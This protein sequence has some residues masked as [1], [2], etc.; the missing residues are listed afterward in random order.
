MADKVKQS[1]YNKARK[2][3][4]ILALSVPDALKDEATKVDRRTHHK[5]DEKVMPDT[6]QFSIYGSVVPQVS[7]PSVDAPYAG[8][9]LKVS[10]HTRPE[11]S[12]ITVNFTIDNQFNNYWY[13]WKWLD[14]LNDSKYSHY[15]HRGPNTTESLMQDYQT[16]ISI[17]GLNE[18]NKNSVKFTY[19][20]AFPVSLGEIVYN[21]RDPGEI[22][23]SF[24]FAFSQML[25][26]L[27]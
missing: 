15:D 18:F 4:F 10:G 24:S 3:K 11:Y 27:L 20:Q 19:T 7:V 23:T 16:N 22:E 17:Y 5:S 12:D 8:Q 25:V 1:I 26:S 13:I 9:H 21:H 14:I 2:D 6:L